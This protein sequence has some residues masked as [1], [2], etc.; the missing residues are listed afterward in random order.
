MLMGVILPALL[1]LSSRR[2]RCYR[3]VELSSLAA[4]GS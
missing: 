1:G 3:L 2:I 4:L